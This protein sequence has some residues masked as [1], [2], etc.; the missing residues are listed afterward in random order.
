MSIRY[1]KEDVLYLEK[2]KR[3]NLLQKRN[4]ELSRDK[5]TRVGLEFTNKAL[6]DRQE[7]YEKQANMSHEERMQ[8]DIDESLDYSLSAKKYI[9]E[10]MLN[11]VFNEIFPKVSFDKEMLIEL[12]RI[13]NNPDM[14]S[15][16]EVGK[17]HI[18]L[19]EKAYIKN[20]R[21]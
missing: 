10:D 21:P 15:D 16:E 20:Y 11:M 18:E 4:L 3:V 6:T 2:K 14:F 8:Q 1:R 17:A 19:E 9:R 12:L 13:V 7:Y 5:I